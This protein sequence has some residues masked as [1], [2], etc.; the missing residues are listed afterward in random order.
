MTGLNISIILNSLMI[1][2]QSY[3]LRTPVLKALE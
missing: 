3:D 2:M 1:L